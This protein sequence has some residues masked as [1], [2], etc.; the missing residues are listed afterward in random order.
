MK[1]NR[2]LISREAF[3]NPDK[4]YRGL[5]IVH[6][7]TA[8]RGDSYEEKAR[9][10][11]EI[12]WGGVVTNDYWDENY[13]TDKNTLNELN[14]FVQALHK[15]G[16]RV[17][18]YDEKG[19]PSGSA[20][21]LT[22]KED[23]LHQAINLWQ[24][25]V[26][27]NGSGSETFDLPKDFI[28]LISISIL[29]EGKYTLVN[30]DVCDDKIT[31]NGV[32]GDWKAYIYCVMKYDHSYNTYAQSY[33]NL[34]NREAVKSYID[35]TFET[36]LNS[37]DNFEEI[38]EAIFD[39]EPYL[40]A[41]R[42]TADASEKYPAIP[43]DYDIF[44]T[45]KAKY[46]YDIVPLLPLVFNSFEPEAQ[47]ARAQYFSHV[48]D[49]FCESFFEQIAEWC[50]AHN[51]ILSGHLLLEEEMKYHIP[52]HGDYIQCS[53]R[54]GYPG[55][56][57]LNPRPAQYIEWISTG[58]KYAS[59]PA[60]LDDKERV[61]MEICPVHDSAEWATN[62]LDYALGTMTFVYFDG[63]NQLASYYGQAND[64]AESGRPFN[65]YIGR[66]GS[67]V[68]G[69]QN[70]NQV[71]VFYAI[72]A[73]GA[74]YVPPVTQHI[75]HP[76]ERARVNDELVSRLALSI[77]A[78]GLD[79]VFLDE[80]SMAKGS[81]ADNALKVGNFDFNTII[82]PH[83]TVMDIKTARMLDKLIENGVNVIFV[84]EMPSL[85]FMAEDQ[86]ELETIMK[87]HESGLKTDVQSAVDA[88]TATVKLTVSSSSVYV[89]PYEK[90][91]TEF[92]FLANASDADQDVTF[93]YDGAARY[94]IYDPA[95]A[96]IT[97]ADKGY[98]VRSYR[99]IFVQPI[100][101]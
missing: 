68:V 1:Q 74:A 65:E 69:A 53:H 2:E 82:V 95:T 36:Y 18:I 66:M 93:N 60:W 3:S 17:W 22:V 55:F 31:F 62:H 30:G 8:P 25:T 47:R 81:L 67:L 10:I 37:I 64:S 43:Y 57:I 33:P 42:H 52:V 24:F 20:G 85:A 46:G 23:G 78:K 4:K 91:G 58:A 35:V 61:F 99:G 49:L 88:I 100:L 39:D 73:V 50:R 90:D 19:Y 51:T 97:E 79:Y 7:Y 76:N 11:K 77:R 21:G 80:E 98:T 71:A 86:A 29:S 54:M 89:S 92:Y 59:S 63:G 26:E 70:K 15:E 101:D 40:T 56:D 32:E 38:V 44:D 96:E 12:G 45:F 13:L 28:K 6:E 48:G 87:K 72:D 16:L 84:D 5:R 83:A 75:Y 27:G 94:R 14:S 9:I 41:T 34:I